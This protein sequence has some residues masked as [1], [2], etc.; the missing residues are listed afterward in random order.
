MKYLAIIAILLLCGCETTDI[1]KRNIESI[2][3]SKILNVFKAQPV[4]PEEIEVEP[5]IAPEAE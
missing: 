5:E 1:I 3:N 2:G 4:E